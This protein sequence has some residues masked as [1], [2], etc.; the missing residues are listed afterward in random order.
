MPLR[1]K[2]S[3]FLDPHHP[4]HYGSL[5]FIGW[6]IAMAV[7]VPGVL[8]PKLMTGW[9]GEVLVSIGPIAAHIYS[10]RALLPLRHNKTLQPNMMAALFT[11]SYVAAGILAELVLPWPMAFMI[12]LAGV[13]LAIF[14]FGLLFPGLSPFFAYALNVKLVRPQDGGWRLALGF[15][16]FFIGWVIA[17]IVAEVI[18]SV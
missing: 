17:T 12:P 16:L 2:Q 5:L 4:Y 15:F 6:A 3:R 10:L 8:Y 13:A 11:L 14:S 1:L 7:A 9:F 18:A